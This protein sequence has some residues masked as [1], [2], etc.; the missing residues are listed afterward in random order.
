MTP[1][2]AARP[3]RRRASPAVHNFGIQEYMPY[4]EVVGDV[5]RINYRREGGHLFIDDTPGISV[6]IDEEKAKKYPYV[7]AS[8]PVNR[9]EDGTLFHW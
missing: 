4:A 5:F 2:T 1:T 6:D 7:M 9:K 3:S 8:L